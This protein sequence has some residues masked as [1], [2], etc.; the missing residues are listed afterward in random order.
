MPRRAIEVANLKPLDYRK[1]LTPREAIE[2][3]I[4]HF[5]DQLKLADAI[6]FSQASVSRVL[7]HGKPPPEM[8]VNIEIATGGKI[9][10]EKLRPDIF[11]EKVSLIKNPWRPSL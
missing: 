6:G 8:C 2:E 11:A 5:G 4:K 10:R 9:T 7:A 3:A 1:P